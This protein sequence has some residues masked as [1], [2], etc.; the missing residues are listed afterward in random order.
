MKNSTK[1]ASAALAT[2]V[3]SAL[4][5]P[6]AVAAERNVMFEVFTATW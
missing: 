2:V 1:I 4:I 6:A 3:A 5:T